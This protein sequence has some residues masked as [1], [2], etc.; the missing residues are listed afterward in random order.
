MD[1][2]IAAKEDSELCMQLR[3]EMLRVVNGLPADWPF[4][5]AF[6]GQSRAYFAQADQTTV[7]AIDDAGQ[8]VGCATLCYIGLMPTFDHPT[9]R[10]AH[11][12]NV[13]TRRACRRQGAARRMV[14]LLVGEARRRGVTEISLDT[15]DAGRPLYEA[16]G[17]APSQ[18][19][20]VLIL[21]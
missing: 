13:Y 3:L 11:L 10:R 17:F 4:S 14:E 15:T 9:G 20:M 1:Y 21:H 18:E 19:G 16:C 8:A 7:L 12:M 2:R 6:V 5:A